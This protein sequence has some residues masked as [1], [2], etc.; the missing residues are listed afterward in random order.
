[1]FCSRRL[2]E[3]EE[4]W[5]E[6]CRPESLNELGSRNL[7]VLDNEDTL[8]DLALEIIREHG[9]A[10]GGTRFVK[11]PADLRHPLC[12]GD[13]GSRRGRLFR[14]ADELQKIDAEAGQRSFNVSVIGVNFEQRFGLR[15]AFFAADRLEQLL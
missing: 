4:H 14:A 9:D 15:P 13:N 7:A 6:R 1:M 2:T 10:A 5:L 12:D 11:C 3:I 8:F